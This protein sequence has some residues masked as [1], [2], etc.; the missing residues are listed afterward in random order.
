MKLTKSKLKELIKEE[1]LEA[2]SEYGAMKDFSKVAKSGKKID[3]VYQYDNEQLVVE[4]KGGKSFL[5]T[6]RSYE[7]D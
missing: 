5:I 4:F 3:V 7:E 1:L 2:R 6:V